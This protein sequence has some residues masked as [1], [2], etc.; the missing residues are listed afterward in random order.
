MD[1]GALIDLLALG[2]TELTSALTDVS[3]AEAPVHPS[4]GKWS[5]LECVEHVVCSEVQMLSELTVGVPAGA[6]R[7]DPHREERILRRGPDRSVKVESPPAAM[8]T[9]RFR[10][11][12]EAAHAFRDVRA[13]TVAFARDATHDPGSIDAKH[14][15]VGTVTGRELLLIIAVHARRHALQVIE[16]KSA[17]RSNV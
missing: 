11:L 7:L 6:P 15:V 14:P 4:A 12:A 16:I 17:L 3:D 13:Q 10:D 9:G 5:I 1:R 8:P 2:E